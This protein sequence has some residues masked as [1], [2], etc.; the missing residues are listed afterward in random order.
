M[1]SPLQPDRQR[2]RE[3]IPYSPIW[4]PA[5]HYFV[6]QSK[7][8]VKRIFAAEDSEIRMQDSGFRIQD[9]GGM[10]RLRRLIHIG[11]AESRILNPESFFSILTPEASK[12]LAGGCRA[13][14]TPGNERTNT[15]S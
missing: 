13:A 15:A 2:P 3:Q 14:T 11:D 6:M 12:R 9:S 5:S 8:R 1:Q 4:M 7:P 10:H